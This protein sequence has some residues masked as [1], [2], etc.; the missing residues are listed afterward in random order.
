MN[1]LRGSLRGFSGYLHRA[2][3]IP[4]DPTRLVRRALCGRPLP[5]TIPEADQKK[6]L[7]AIDHPRDHL[8]FH[9]MLRTGI[10]LGSA[11]ALDVSDLDL[12][13][14]EIVL[15]HAKGD[16]EERVYLPKGIRGEVATFLKGISAG[17]VFRGRGEQR[18]GSRHAQ[19]RLV[20][21]AAKAGIERAFSPH[22][23][24]HSF[25]TG[26]YQR[27]GDILLV[28]RALRHRSITSTLVY[29]HV[30]EAKVREAIEA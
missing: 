9:L 1:S 28:Q 5:R 14:G 27:T 12:E 7:A 6:L 30:E 25:A 3:I 21:W 15:R 20:Q 22:A 8:L 19:R 24:R 23:L 29:A 26:L 2:G 18:L 11:L 17:P 13:R 10:R 16:R 4:T